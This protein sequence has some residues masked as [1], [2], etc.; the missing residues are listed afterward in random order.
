VTLGAVGPQGPQGLKGPQGLQG[1][2]G[3]TGATGA[4]GP[5]GPPGPQGPSG[6]QGGKGDTGA[7]GPQ[8]PQGPSGAGV[9]AG[10]VLPF[11]GSSAPDG[12]LLCDGS[13]VS[14]SQYASLYAAIATSYGAG[15]GV[16]T[17][18]LPDLRGRVAVGA[19]AGANL[20][21]RALADSFGEEMHTLS[22]AEM[23]SHYHTA[24]KGLGFVQWP[25]A[26]NGGANGDSAVAA[27]QFAGIVAPLFRAT[28]PSGGGLAHNVMQPSLVLNYIIKF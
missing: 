11:A 3:D 6:P 12:Y 5:Q 18:N 26:Q 10:V 8:G 16:T 1:P 21:P 13:A 27:F 9:P 7:A 19:G 24:Q 14:R 28:D 25:N 22:I 23:P 2:K 4:T 15:D 17:F 20:T